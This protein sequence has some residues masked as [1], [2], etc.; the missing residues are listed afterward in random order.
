MFKFNFADE[1]WPSA[2]AVTTWKIMPYPRPASDQAQESESDGAAR[3]HEQSLAYFHVDL[4]YPIAA[5]NVPMVEMCLNHGAKVNKRLPLVPYQGMTPL[6]KAVATAYEFTEFDS[7]RTILPMRHNAR[8]IIQLLIEHGA[9]PKQVDVDGRDAEHV[10]K[11]PQVFLSSKNRGPLP[12]DWLIE[13]SLETPPDPDVHRLFVLT[14]AVWAGNVAKVQGLLSEYPELC[15]VADDYRVSPLGVAVY[16]GIEEIA[17]LLLQCGASPN[18]PDPTGS[19]PLA[20]AVAV[21][22]LAITDLLLEHGAKTDITDPFLGLLPLEYAAREGNDAMCEKIIAHLR[23]K[24]RSEVAELLSKPLCLAVRHYQIST[25]RLL[26]DHRADVT[27]NMLLYL[28]DWEKEAY[29][30][31]HG[32]LLLTTMTPRTYVENKIRERMLPPDLPSTN[33]LKLLI[34]REKRAGRQSTSRPSSEPLDWH[35][36]NLS[37]KYRR[38]S[39]RRSFLSFNR[40]STDITGGDIS[41]P[42]K[43]SSLNLPS[44]PCT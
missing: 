27:T 12:V 24:D 20:I 43:D 3:A 42:S 23:H 25:V 36:D 41:T 32:G 18:G 40:S 8:K 28:A 38:V 11:N 30:G 4:C 37:S 6:M 9:D 16:C 33:L 31:A 13:Q 17:R 26:L 7:I 29:R 44:S 35:L 14:D 5:G 19:S 22:R 15:H 39:K 2:V 10:A 1:L 21:D 34:E